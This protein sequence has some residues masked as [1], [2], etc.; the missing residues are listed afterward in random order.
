MGGVYGRLGHRDDALD[1]RATATLRHRG[2]DHAALWIDA[3]QEPALALGH[4]RLAVLDLSA[5]AHQPLHTDDGRYVLAFDGQL[6]N[7]RPLRAALERA[8]TV[9][10]S[11]GDTEVV[12]HTLVRYGDA[13]LSKLEGMFALALWDRLERRLLLARDCSGI[14]PLF[15]R[16]GPDMLAFASEIKALLVDPEM[17]RRPNLQRLAGFLH[18]LYVPAPGTAFEGIHSVAPGHALSWRP[19]RIDVVR[20]HQFTLEPKVTGQP[21]A[22]AV[23]ELERLLKEVLHEQLVADVPVGALLSGGLDSGVMLALMLACRRERG[24]AGPLQTLTISV[25][26]QALDEAPRAARL[27]KHLS[28]QRGDVVHEVVQLGPEDAARHFEMIADQFDEPFAH[29]TVIA[30][31]VLCAFARQ[32]VPI[33]LAGDGADEAFAGYT[34]YRGTHLLQAWRWLPAAVRD[35]LG[36]VERRLP[37]RARTLPL[38]HQARRFVRSTESNFGDNYRD[39]LTFH[40]QSELWALLAD[41]IREALGGELP[42]DLGNTMASLAEVAGAEPVDAACYADI[43]GYLPD[44]VLRESDR[45]SMRHGLEIRVPFAD[46]RIL[47]HGL[48]LPVDQKLPAR[49]MMRA[50]GATGTKKILRA[51]AARY[52]PKEVIVAPK[53]GFGAPVG[54]WLKGPLRALMLDA[55][56]PALIRRRGLLRPEAVER[57]RAEHLQGHR[58]HALSLWSLMVLESWLQRRIDRLLLPLGDLRAVAVTVAAS[59]PQPPR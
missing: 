20:F 30:H 56:D 16:Q 19:G 15:W 57:L 14:K 37:E 4:T 17:P 22:E 18:Y 52:L 11:S 36:A 33:V 3:S 41:P 39:W 47:Q 40:S 53:Q 51:L 42:L 21:M 23:Q 7:W 13:G 50:A 58:D 48:L 29:P 12:L 38:V 59:P 49:T 25:A 28:G 1:Q 35:S 27:V 24:V 2:P 9:F 31:D 8:G 32:R 44:N 5:A 54:G 46:R 34:R 6:Y 26:G 43:G 10:H 55:T 45:V